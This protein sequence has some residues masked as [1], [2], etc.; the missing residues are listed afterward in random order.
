MARYYRLGSPRGV[1]PFDAFG[2]H[3]YAGKRDRTVPPRRP[4]TIRDDATPTDRD[5]DR[6]AGGGPPGVPSW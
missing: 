3:R 5:L 6:L 2:R 1:P 4:M